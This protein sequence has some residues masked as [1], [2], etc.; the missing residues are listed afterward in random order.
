[1]ELMSCV[2][3]DPPNAAAVSK[4][5]N[6]TAPNGGNAN[7]LTGNPARGEARTGCLRIYIRVSCQ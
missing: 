3:G 4:G 5:R 1:M 6:G 2:P 7:D